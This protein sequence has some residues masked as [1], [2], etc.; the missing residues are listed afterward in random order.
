MLTFYHETLLNSLPNFT[1]VFVGSVQFPMKTV[2]SPENILISFQSLCLLFLSCLIVLAGTFSALLNR[3]S[4][5][6]HPCRI[7]SYKGK[8]L[9]V[10]S[11]DMLLALG[12]S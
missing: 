12:F 1:S 3:S 9:N 4:D 8:G 11:L 10:S 5:S 2:I 6:G 7:L